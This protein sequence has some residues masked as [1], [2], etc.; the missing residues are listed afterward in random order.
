RRHALEAD[1]LG[2]LLVGGFGKVGPIGEDDRR[3]DVVAV[4]ALLHR[5]DP[6]GVD[7]DVVPLERDPLVAEEALGPSAVRAPAR[8]V[9]PD[10]VVH[11][12]PLSDQ[13]TR[14]WCRIRR[15]ALHTGSPEVEGSPRAPGTDGGADYARAERRPA[16]PLDPRGRLRRARGGGRAGPRGVGLAPRRPDGRA[17]RAQ[18]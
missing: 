11:P 3:D 8:P 16:R 10:D 9:D 13:P 12:A 1:L 14:S 5:S 15:R 7:L 17:F 2:E 6:V 4:V 18:P